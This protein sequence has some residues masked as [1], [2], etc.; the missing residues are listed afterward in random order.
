MIGKIK[1][2]NQGKGYGFIKIEGQKDIFVH[3]DSIVSEE[4]R[5]KLKEEDEVEFE[6]EEGPKGIQA[7][8]VNLINL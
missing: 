8:R 6:L 5:K 7:A 4:I 1:W 2:F 3:Y